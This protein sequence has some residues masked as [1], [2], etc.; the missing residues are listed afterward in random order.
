MAR[1]HVFEPLGMADTT[2]GASAP[3]QK[4]REAR[5]VLETETVF[6]AANNIGGDSAR[7]AWTSARLSAQRCSLAVANCRCCP[8]YAYA[9]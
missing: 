5:C 2:L 7:P 4:Q 3:R 8:P 6:M 9:A 1:E